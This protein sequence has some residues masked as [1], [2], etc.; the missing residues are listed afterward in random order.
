MQD[1]WKG[2]ENFEEHLNRMLPRL[3]L[4]SK[5]VRF[6]CLGLYLAGGKQLNSP[7]LRCLW[8]HR[9]KSFPMWLFNTD[10]YIS[11][12]AKHTC[13]E[14]LHNSASEL[15]HMKLIWIYLQIRLPWALSCPRIRAQPQHF[16]IHCIFSVYT[17]PVSPLHSFWQHSLCWWAVSCKCKQ[18]KCCWHSLKTPWHAVLAAWA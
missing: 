18:R 4:L 11:L 14:A 12:K 10:F 3:V 5:Y 2:Q 16:L 8:W 6:P 9:A 17:M 1:T 7:V 15:Q 13:C